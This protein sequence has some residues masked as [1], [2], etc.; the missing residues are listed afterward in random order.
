MNSVRLFEDV[1]SWL[2]N[3]AKRKNFPLSPLFISG[4]NGKKLEWRNLEKFWKVVIFSRKCLVMIFFKKIFGRNFFGKF[5]VVN[6]SRKFLVVNFSRNFLVVNFSKKVLVVNVSRKCLV[7]IFS[8]KYTVFLKIPRFSYSSF[9][10]VP[11]FH[12]GPIWQGKIFSF[13]TIPK[14]EKTKIY[15]F[16]RWKT[17]DKTQHKI[18]SKWSFFFTLWLHKHIQISTLG[19][20]QNRF[21]FYKVEPVCA[22][23]NLATL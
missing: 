10:P 4:W 11:P 13:C 21:R 1:G 22:K 18:F 20:S 8:R 3:S 14:F 15:F 16:Y 17:T 19:H 23:S 7:M 5:L 2:R 12:F 9:S 6:F